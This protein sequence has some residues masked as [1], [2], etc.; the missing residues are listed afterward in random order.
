MTPLLGGC[1]DSS[2][3]D[4][5][6]GMSTFTARRV[7]LLGGY[8]APGTLRRSATGARELSITPKPRLRTSDRTLTQR[9]VDEWFARILLNLAEARELAGRTESPAL[10]LAVE[11]LDGATLNVLRE[12]GTVPGLP[13]VSDLVARAITRRADDCSSLRLLGRDLRGF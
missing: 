2:P 4:D 5:E 3:W 9:D 8:P 13:D 12:L 1:D 6:G 7:G 10:K 11:A